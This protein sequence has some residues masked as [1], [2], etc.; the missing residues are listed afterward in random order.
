MPAR[1]PEPAKR[2]ARPQSCSASGAGLRRAAMSART[3]VAAAS[4][5]PGVM[6]RTASWQSEHD[7][8]DEDQPHDHQ[9]QRGNEVVA[10]AELHIVAGDVDGGLQDAEYDKHP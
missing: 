4:F 9:H 7:L 8:D 6:L 5:A 10:A 2:S 3:S 1:S